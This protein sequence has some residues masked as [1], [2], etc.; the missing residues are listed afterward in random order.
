MNDDRACI[1]RK[2]NDLAP[3]QRMKAMS[4][5]VAVITDQILAEKERHLQRGYRGAVVAALARDDFLLGGE[6][7]WPVPPF[8]A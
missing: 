1:C 8:F 3:G 7:T 6:Q 4:A 5:F 2:D